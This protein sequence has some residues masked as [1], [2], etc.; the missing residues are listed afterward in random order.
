VLTNNHVI[1]GATSIS[2]TDLGNGRVYSA[3]VVGY[4]RSGDIAVLQLNGASGLRVASLGDSSKV[5]KGEPV[6]AIGNLGG[7]GG[8]PSVAGGS[9]TGLSKTI[10]ASDQN[11]G[12]PEQL[13]GL[14]EINAD[15]Q[16]GDSGGP[17][18]NTAGK[19]VGIDTAASSNFSFQSTST[20]GYAIPINAALA[21]AHQIES[22]GA[23]S[24]V[25]VGPTAFLG[26]EVVAGSQSGALL[27]GV[28]GGSPAASAGLA[29]GDVITSLGGNTVSSPASLTTLMESH[30]PGDRVE[31]GWTDTAGNHH[32]AMVRLTT[33]P[34]A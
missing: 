33:G 17:L 12:N 6:V 34:A 24:T 13:T 29:A 18:V 25:H 22:G 19:V 2:V 14:I 31:V 11:G 3:T 10:T 15:I 8:T 32:G 16:P 5:S 21:I 23:S 26:V 28:V 9:V 27:E 30:H 20:Q 1:D 7:A 4:D